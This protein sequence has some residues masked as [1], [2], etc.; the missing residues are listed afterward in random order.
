MSPAVMTLPKLM[1]ASTDDMD[2]FYFA[3]IRVPDAFVC[4]EMP[5]GQRLAVVNALEFGRVQRAGV[6]DQVFA[7]EALLESAKTMPWQKASR[8]VQAILQL[9]KE[10]GLTACEVAEHFPVKLAWELQ[11]SGLALRVAEGMFFPQRAFKN[12]DEARWIAQGNAV[13]SA[14]FSV[15]ERLLAE[16]RVSSD[17]CL[18]LGDEVLTSERVRA[19]IDLRAW[20]LGA[21]SLH[22]IVAGG[23]QAC[24]PHHEGAGSLFAN[25]LIIVDIFPQV[26]ATGYHG[27]MTRTYLKGQPSAEQRKLVDT[28]LAAQQESIA[29]H[30][31]GKPVKALYE[32]VCQRFKDAGF[33][34]ERRQGLPVGFFHGLGHGLGLAVHE[35][36]RVSRADGCLE[37]GHVVTVEPGLYYPG[38]GGCRIE[39]VVRITEG[40]P[41]LLSQHAYDWI[42]D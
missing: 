14:G 2:V 28:V 42:I 13:S 6:F 7:E 24:D 26:R 5:D 39:D 16:A 33:P 30:V 17:G 36:P 4:L 18:L 22:T 1:Y 38:L 37:V 41:E 29:E 27:D 3:R 10:L 34:T 19:E 9:T 21:L 35:P 40:A 15:V 11:A 32:T 25:S 12:D 8:P 31:A 20:E 23:D